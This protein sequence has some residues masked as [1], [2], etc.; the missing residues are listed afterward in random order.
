VREEEKKAEEEGRRL[1]RLVDT[2]DRSW[3]W[4]ELEEV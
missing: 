3:S 1:D 4:R 2:T